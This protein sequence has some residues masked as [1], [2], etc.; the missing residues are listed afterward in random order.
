MKVLYIEDSN[1]DADLTRRALKKSA[2][3]IELDI[4]ASLVEG[5]ARLSPSA[6]YDLLLSDLSLPDGSGLAALNYVRE[7]KLPLAVVILTGSGDQNAAIAA[8]KAGADDYLVKRNDYLN[9]L[10]A[11]LHLAMTRFRDSVNR[12]N[13]ILRVLQVEHNLFDSDLTRRHLAHHAPHIH[14]T[15]VQNGPEALACLPDSNE[16]SSDFDVLL[17]DYR[18][19][20]MDGLELAKVLREKRGL[21]IPIVLVTGQGSEDIAVRALHLGVDDYLAKREG[22][23]FELPATLE[24]VVHL[25]ELNRERMVLKRTGQRLSR[26]LA[27]SPTILYNLRFSEQTISTT[28]ISDNVE[29][30]LGYT[31]EQALLPGWWQMHLFPADRESVIASQA[32]LLVDDQLIH[33]YRF[34]CADSRIIWLRDELKLIRDDQGQPLEVVGAWLDVSEHKRTEAVRLA[35]QSVLDRIVANQPLPLILDDIATRVEAIYPDMRVAIMLLDPITGC[36]MQ[37]AAPS[38]PEFYNKTVDCLAPGEGRRSC[39]TAAWRGEPVIVSDIEHHPFWSAYLDLTRRAGL[40]ACCSI[41]YKDETGQVLGTFAVY[42]DCVREPLADEWVLVEEF[43]RITALAVQKVRA[44]ES[45][46]QAAAVFEAT[47]EGILITDLQPRI[48]AINRAYSEIT[49]YSEVEVLGKNP[50]YLQSGR[51]DAAFYQALWSRLLDTGHWQGEIWNRR[52]NGELYPQWLTIST[53]YDDQGLPYQYVG[54]F[55]DISQIKQSEARLEHMAHY[56]PLTDLPNRL[57]V[58]SRLLHAIERAQRHRHKVAV[59]YLDLDH[60]KTVNDSLGHPCGDELLSLLAS[61]LISRLREED[62]LARLG[63]DEFLLVLEQIEQAEVAATVAQTMIELLKPS[64]RLSNGHEIYLGISIG[65]SLFPDDANDVTELIQHADMAMYL[66]KQEGRNTFRFHTQALSSAASERLSL[67]TR[68]RR[69][70]ID[71]EFI[72]HY[73]LLI[74]VNTGQFA[75]VEAL[76]R[77][78]PPG[79]DMVPPGKFIPIAEE[80]GLI[81]PLGEWVLRTACKQGRAWLDAGLPAMIVAVNLSGRQ[82][83]SADVVALVRQVLANTGFPAQYLELELTEG[84]LM[85]NAKHSIATLNALKDLGVRLSID[86]FGT[87]YSSLAYLKQFPIDKLK[88]DQ[89]FI[90]GLVDDD[91]DREITA[92][93]IAMSHILK[94]DVLA[95]GVETEQQLD[96]VRQHGCDYYQGYLSH[97]PEPAALVEQRLRDRA[98]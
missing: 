26:V 61:R 72:L 51:H 35:R 33:E 89:S 86:D 63:G 54:V 81:V 94:L 50:N 73:Q 60:F 13:R 46:R 8:L 28:W 5:L 18:L 69:A 22:Y 19:P 11:A 27:A 31:M 88:I 2:P 21:D 39:G 92:T 24:K 44:A 23:L 32:N 38:L 1:N 14:L 29:R 45:L 93:I 20:G 52:K 76:V 83:Q 91:N 79:E 71:S 37:G 70:L 30:L 97:R 34:I 78:Q 53:V 58:Q 15:S 65:I 49:G 82:F 67:D 17:I 25:A 41:P 9:R 48:V 95:E 77:W 68:L 56:D 6:G 87:G 66:A 42:Y 98:S 3:D 7:R 10:P 43:T 90:R 4:A 16:A 85:D 74:N 80:T 64:F 47:R 12:S 36:L 57:L 40:R 55:S 59:L 62:T 84:M 96:F 75:G